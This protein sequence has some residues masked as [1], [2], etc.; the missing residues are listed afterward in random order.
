M[1]L[2]Q[3]GPQDW[4]SHL[5][6]DL[7][8]TPIFASNATEAALANAPQ[9]HPHAVYLGIGLC[10]ATQLSHSCLPVDTLGFIL[11]AE[12]VRKIID[13]S[14]L[15]ILIADAH[16]IVSGF[17]PLDV[18]RQAKILTRTL[19]RARHRL[20]LDNLCIIRASALHQHEGYQ[21]TL[22]GIIHRSEGRGNPYIWH[23][24]ADVAYLDE[25]C[26]GILKVGWSIRDN[27]IG[28]TQRDEPAFDSLIKSL[29]H[30]HPSFVYTCSGR[31][32]SSKRPRVSPYITVAPETRILLHP[33]EDPSK[34][35]S[36]LDSASSNNAKSFKKY[37]S[38][39]TQVCADHIPIETSDLSIQLSSII[40]HIYPN[41]NT[42][43]IEFGH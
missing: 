2:K 13:A 26:D 28:T 10:T 31:S 35:L 4:R 9:K 5:L 3:G 14:T 25:I 42:S 12:R 1:R 11:A 24:T 27:I 17:N 20:G 8:N 23:Q 16:A 7:R 38:S 36:L 18:Q 15:I 6:Q 41:R 43:L 22:H 39:V 40:H 37:M 34:K 29:S 33:K 21:R 32:M 19:L 30:R